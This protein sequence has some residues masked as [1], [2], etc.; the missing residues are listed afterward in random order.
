MGVVGVKGAS[1][2]SGWQ[3]EPGLAALD[4]WTPG[5]ATKRPL[6]CGLTTERVQ[7]TGT[8]GPQAR[9]SVEASPVFPRLLLLPLIWTVCGVCVYVCK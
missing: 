5:K 3:G 1:S 2:S 4:R 6:R 9:G 8:K 7:L